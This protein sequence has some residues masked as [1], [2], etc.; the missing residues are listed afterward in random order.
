MSDD[1]AEEPTAEPDTDDGTIHVD[2]APEGREW[3]HPEGDEELSP[4]D[5]AA[6]IEERKREIGH[7]D[8][9]PDDEQ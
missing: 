4:E 2:L 8:D 3:M 5:L 6:M 1:E 9:D 7:G